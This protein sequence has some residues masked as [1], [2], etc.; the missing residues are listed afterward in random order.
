MRWHDGRVWF[1]DMYARRVLS[2]LEDGTDLRVEG[3][4]PA[5]SVGIDWL[6]DGRLLVTQWEPASLLR[7]EPDGN[8]VVHSDLSAL[9][10]SR[11]ND[12]IVMPD[13]S[14]IVGCFGF[15]IHGNADFRTSRLMRVSPDGDA[16]LVGEPS[17]FPNGCA[18]L[19]GGQAMVVAESFGNRMSVY[20]VGVDG[21]LTNRRDWATFGPMPTATSLAERFGQMVVGCDGIS[22]PDAEGAI[23]VA[24][25]TG[26]RAIRV[27]PGGRIADTVTTARNL[28]CFCP[29][30]GGADGR[31]LFLCAAPGDYDPD[32]DAP[33]G[34]VQACRV[35]VPLAASA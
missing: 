14:A 4:L 20:D 17:F 6:P 15:D 13:G 35:D 21:A 33:A 10:D 29:A 28:N 31:T 34:T 30:L 3:D 18:L 19:D 23:W 24:D 7:R 2:V 26:D 9:C 22:K 32:R 27:L 5:V 16:S 8:F 1:S 25:F 12:L 11:L